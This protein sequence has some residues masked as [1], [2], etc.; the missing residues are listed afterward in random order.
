MNAQI[1]YFEVIPN[2]IGLQNVL[3]T[4]KWHLKGFQYIYKT[5]KAMEI[6][7]SFVVELV[8]T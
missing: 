7:S 5:V 1:K 4:L 3:D 8:K 2:D 6:V